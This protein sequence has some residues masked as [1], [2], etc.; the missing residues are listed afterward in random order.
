VLKRE[1]VS[2]EAL[3]HGYYFQDDALP[4]I[5]APVRTIGRE[6]RYVVVRGNVVAG[7]AYEA[8]T[9]S[10][11]PDTAGGSPWQLAS[12]IAAQMKAP[13]DVYVLDICEADGDLR[14]LELNPFSGADLYACDRRSVVAAVSEFARSVFE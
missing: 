13:E 1:A 12:R 14:L 3:D 8:A 5:V 7:S 11:R 9:R 6:W 4:V 2:L 10:S